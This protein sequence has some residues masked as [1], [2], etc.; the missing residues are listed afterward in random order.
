MRR[1]R[2]DRKGDGRDMAAALL[3]WLVVLVSRAVAIV[4]LHVHSRYSRAT[5]RDGDLEHLAWW[6]ARK[7]IALLGTGDVTH[8]AWFAEVADRLVPAEDGLYRLRPDLERDVSATLPASCRAP[9]RFLLSVEISTIYKRDGRTR[10]VHH[11]CYFPDLDAV[12]RFNATLGGIG[13]IASDGRPI[14]GLDSR[15]LLEI[16]LESGPGAYLVPAHVWTPWFAVLGSMSGFDAVADCYADLAGHVFAVETGLSSD[17][18]MNWRVSGLDRYRL[19]SNSDAHSPSALG[20]EATVLDVG[21]LD[22]WSVRRALETGEGFAGTLEFFPEEGKYHLDGHRRCDVRWDPADTR[23]HD[24]RCPG[25]G[26]PVTVGVLSRVEA[27]A[28]RAEGHVPAGA[29]G[30]RSLVQLP[31][32]VGEVLGVGSKSKAVARVVEDLVERLGPELA[33]LQDVPPA[34][35]AAVL[36]G[37]LAEAVTRLRAGQVHRDAGYD[38]EYG[39]IRLFAPAELSAPAAPSLFPLDD[40]APAAPAPG[41]AEPSAAAELAAP[42]GPAA[43]T[44]PA[45]ATRAPAAG[46]GDRLPGFELP[47]RRRPPPPRRRRPPL[48]RLPGCWPGW[49]R[50]SAR[51]PGRPARCSS[52]PGRGPARPAPSPTAS[53]TW[54]PS[55]ASGRSPASR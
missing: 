39:T 7:G 32:V 19:V 8:P 31:Q 13:N 42:A 43:A 51:R 27:L 36:P 50:S 29:P 9:V 14:L 54:S 3:L 46:H 17:P 10:K 20:R 11:L 4:D 34:E 18:A 47:R 53:P 52:S 55:A 24:A 25:C 15:D 2:D 44:A 48:P 23:R 22:Y 6:G 45:T 33:I 12:R 1:A 38:G 28:D 16:T 26:R 21:D 41:A 35:I 40:A 37:P 5:S 49:T 30:F